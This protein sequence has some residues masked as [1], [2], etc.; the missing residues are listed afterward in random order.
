MNL[1]CYICLWTVEISAWNICT[2]EFSPWWFHVRLVMEE[3]GLYRGFLRISSG[4]FRLI[5]I[6]QLLHTNLSRPLRCEISVIRQHSITSSV[7]KLGA[8]SLMSV[9]GCLQNKEIMLRLSKCFIKY[10]YHDQVIAHVVS[11]R[12]PTAAAR[13]RSQA[14]PF[15]ICDRQ[16][17]TGVGFLWVLRFP[18]PI[19][20]APNAL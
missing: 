18:L 3:V 10:S 19:L 15:R 11:R 9:H 17:G 12:L 8:S 4:I 7:F 16:I 13:V 1:T 5:S 2:L 20:I 14:R 6:P